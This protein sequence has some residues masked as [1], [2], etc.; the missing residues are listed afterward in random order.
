MATKFSKVHTILPGEPCE[1]CMVAALPA[2]PSDARLLVHD[3]ALRLGFSSARPAV[4]LLADWNHDRTKL[5]ILA[6]VLETQTG[7]PCGVFVIERADKPLWA[8][9]RVLAALECR[10]FFFL[11]AGSFPDNEAWD[12]ALAALAVDD[13]ELHALRT[14][15][16]DGVAG[17]VWNSRE[18]CSWSRSGLAVGAR[19]TGSLADI[20]HWLAGTATF[21]DGDADTE[22]VLDDVDNLTMV[23]SA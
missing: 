3:I 18:F 5:P 23:M 15:D 11:T 1:V 6:Q 4:A 20:A 22:Q 17:F 19:H 7:R 12:A 8:L 10:R 2:N 13:P 9:P 21:L 16:G 14:R